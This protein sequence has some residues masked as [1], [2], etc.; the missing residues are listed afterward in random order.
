MSDQP[1]TEFP[2]RRAVEDGR[3]SLVIYGQE[4]TGVSD[5]Y[6]QVLTMPVWLL[7]LL[8]ATAYLTINT[9]FGLLYMA[10]PGSVT[11][12]KPGSFL[13]A[14]FSPLKAVA[15]SLKYWISVPGSGPS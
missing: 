14:F 10:V 5:L 15:S 13:D 8:L 6:H 7:L 11:D 4:R 12:A 3:R 9:L 1:I 2:F